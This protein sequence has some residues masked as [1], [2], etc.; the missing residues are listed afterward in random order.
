MSKIP[1]GEIRHAIFINAAPSVVFELL[2]DEQRMMTWLASKVESAPAPG[3]S[4]VI[5]GKDAGEISGE[6]VEVVPGK[7]VVF[8]WG[9]IMG[10]SHGQTTVEFLLEPEG[11]GTRVKLRHYGLPDSVISE[12]SRGWISSGLPKL[13]SAAEGR[14]PGSLC[15]DELMRA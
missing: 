13:K 3:G 5:R 8:T 4:I 9:G 2:T 1:A 10:L 15:L 6:F 11:N 7:K 12:H 14:K